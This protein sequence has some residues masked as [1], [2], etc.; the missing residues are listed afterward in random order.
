MEYKTAEMNNAIN[1]LL[2]LDPASIYI[3]GKVTG[4]TDYKERFAK[5]EKKLHEM[6]P[7][8]LIAN[9]VR[10]T[11]P[12]EKFS[13]ATCMDVDIALLKHCDAIY[14]LHGYED[15]EGAK[16]ELAIA[17]TYH[18]KILREDNYVTEDGTA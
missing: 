2:N 17:K 11:E 5:A 18:I 15:S 7:N 4:T 3:S 6:F 10:V 9:P 1:R 14:M 8:A 13:Y 12:I 16:L